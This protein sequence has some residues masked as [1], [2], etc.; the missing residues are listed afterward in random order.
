MRGI[1]FA[2]F[3]LAGLM[4]RA[5][6][7]GTK[8]EVSREELIVEASKE[9]MLGRLDKAKA[10]Y[11][12]LLTEYPN[13]ELAAYELARILLVQNQAEEA[14]IWAGKAANADPANVWYAILKADALQAMGQYKDA[15]VVYENLVRL[16]PAQNNYY[17]KWAFYLV[18]ANELSA[19]LKIYDDLER[20]IGIDENLIRLK[21]SLYLAQGDQKKA[22]R[23]LQR[24]AEAKPNRTDYWHNLAEFYTQMG[25]KAQAQVVYRKIL[26]LD[27]NDIKANLAL[28]GE[29]V[30]KQNDAQYLGTLRQTFERNDVSLELKLGKIMPLLDM[31]KR[32]ADANLG[33]ELLTLAEMLEQ[34]YPKEAQPLAISATVLSK[35]G[36]KAEAI[37]KMRTAVDL[38]DADFSNWEVLLGDLEMLGDMPGLRKAAESALDVF[39]NRPEI[40]AFAANAELAMS[41]FTAVEDLVNQALP[42]SLKFPALQQQLLCLL[43]MVQT[44]KNN[45]SAANQTF[46]EA[47]KFNPNAASV[48]AWQSLSFALRPN[49]AA[50]ALT[51]AQKA[52]Q[53]EPQLR[54]AVFANAKAQLRSGNTNEAK[55]AVES[56]LPTSNP[57]YLE[58]YG[59]VLFKSG[60][61]NA[62]VQQW[63]V[64]LT[65]GSVSPSL[66]KKIN[67]KQ[68]HE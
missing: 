7:I 53:A 28:A 33:K 19:A 43:A 31:F 66:K 36:K 26:S 11:K 13:N 4:L 60:D 49:G 3:L 59:D 61:T 64:A 17:F 8:K 39:P 5:Q 22:A 2:A 29:D 16:H 40:Y 24:L 52:L 58:H 10:L 42:M 57:M 27:A 68:L 32:N 65:K 1:V 14:I 20:R 30:S 12:Q 55:R 63:T 41:N 34:Q 21:H 56:L 37:A 6:E 50:Q 62:A 15:A 46:G 9:K 45:T 67:E 48:L 23:E 18:K 54:L 25:D 38:D 44:Q 51:L 47:F 35:Q